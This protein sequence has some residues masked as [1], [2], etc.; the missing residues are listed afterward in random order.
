MMELHVCNR[1]GVLL[2]AYALGDS[3][4]VVIGRDA[5]CD[6]RI[7]ASSV[8]REHCAVEWQGRSLV[9]RDLG[10]TGGTYANGNRLD[11]IELRD[12]MEVKIGPAI[13]KFLDS[14]GES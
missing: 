12:G 2:R 13:L 4:E 5:H 3:E 8:S 6:I 14:E 1:Q 11:Q 10:S 9:L 7:A